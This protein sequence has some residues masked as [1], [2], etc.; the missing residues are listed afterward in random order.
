MIRAAE[1]I[2][3]DVS[4]KSPNY[5]YNINF[6]FLDIL[7]NNSIGEYTARPLNLFLKYIPVPGEI[8]SIVESTSTY[9]KAGSQTTAWY[10]LPSTGLY[11]SI[12]YNGLDGASNLS[13]NPSIT[14]QKSEIGN[15]KKS[16]GQISR[17]KQTFILQQ[18]VFPIQPYIGDTILESRFGSSIRMSSTVY[19]SL[20]SPIWKSRTKENNPILI[21]RNTKRDDLGTT[22]F[23]TE[24]LETDDNLLILSSNLQLPFKLSAKSKNI[25]T[26]LNSNQFSNQIYIGS[27]RIILNS[28]SNEIILSSNKD[29]LLSS[30]K[31]VQ[32]NGNAINIDS[33]KITLSPNALEPAVL[34]NQLII[35]LTQI[36]TILNLNP[37]YPGVLAPVIPQLQTIL[38]KYVRLN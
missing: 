30:N 34:G 16:V 26:V 25:L 2:S 36:C 38:S 15:I 4:D 32:L 28:K 8:V 17:D 37:L 20:N 3:V 6:K 19:T 18:N 10:Y 24:N 11:S 29:L 7:S 5:L 33:Y 35:L 21:F 31:N 23:I 1:V 13:I 27:D 22:K 14:Y 9:T 12:H